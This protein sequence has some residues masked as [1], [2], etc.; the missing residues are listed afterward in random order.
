MIKYPKLKADLLRLFIFAIVLTLGAS[1]SIIAAPDL[2]AIESFFRVR[3]DI[4][5]NIRKWSGQSDPEWIL[6]EWIKIT[7]ERGQDYQTAKKILAGK[8]SSSAPNSSERANYSSNSSN[9]EVTSNS[10][11]GSST[12]SGSENP[13]TVS[14][15]EDSPKASS[16]DGFSFSP[17][18][19]GSFFGI[20]PE[21]NHCLSEENL[22]DL[23][24]LGA[25]SVRLNYLSA[26]SLDDYV[27]VCKKYM[28]NGFDIIMLVCYDG[29]SGSY[30]EEPVPWGKRLRYTN[31]H[32]MI[33]KLEEIVPRL[34]AIGV[35]KWEIWN[36]QN[37]HWY[38]SPEEYSDLLC[39]VYKKFKYT[40]KWNPNATIVFGGLDSVVW[41]CPDGINGTAKQYLEDFY[42]ASATVNFK[43]TY[44]HS[45]FDVM[46]THP[47]GA[48]T[49]EKFNNNINIG[50]LE[51]MRKYGDV[52]K[53]IW[54]TEVGNGDPDDNKQ[55]SNIEKLARMS[56]EHPAIEKFYLFKETY[57]GDSDHKHYS[58]IYDGGH[59]R[60]SFYTYRDFIANH[61]N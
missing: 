11:Q 41:T 31:S 26:Y 55:A 30:V 49:E 12:V 9:P 4:R 13:A 16:S 45:P 54:I 2:G 44:N 15:I 58:I 19:A 24:E 20:S 3:P 36:E 43:K 25:T 60:K 51:V 48:I 18:P 59:R 39:E 32:E 57:G 17:K 35:D 1:S 5:D 33:K 42:R 40:D 21:H 23:K 27:N 28:A 46:S 14:S 38:V 47:Y 10:S 50:T 52:N 37:G 56:L 22:R 34:T 53:P 8:V 6:R 29:Y 7:T 61:K